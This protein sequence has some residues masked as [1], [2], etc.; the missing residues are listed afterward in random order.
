MQLSEINITELNNNVVLDPQAEQNHLLREFQ[1]LCLLD[2]KMSYSYI[3]D[4]NIL[5]PPISFP[6]FRMRF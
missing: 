3:F 6:H 2:I 1:Q 5:K 4:D